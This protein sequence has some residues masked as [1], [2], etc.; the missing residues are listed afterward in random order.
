MIDQDISPKAHLSFSERGWI[1]MYQGSPLCD[2]KATHDE[3][4]RVV[5]QYRITLPLVTWNGDRMEWVTTN[6][7]EEVAP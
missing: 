4:M 1:L 7:M 2:Y 3:V 6:T 5:A